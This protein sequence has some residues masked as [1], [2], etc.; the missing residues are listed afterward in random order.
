MKS[1]E[2]SGIE[3]EESPRAEKIAFDSDKI[4][5]LNNPGDLTRP[6]NFVSESESLAEKIAEVRED[7]K[8]IQK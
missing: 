7:L 5:S 2:S 6:E 4:N 1:I 3:I 8:N